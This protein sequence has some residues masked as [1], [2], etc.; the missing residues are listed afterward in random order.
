[1]KNRPFRLN[2]DRYS[3]AANVLELSLLARQADDR[4]HGAFGTIKPGL[5]PTAVM[6]D[7]AKVVSSFQRH[8]GADVLAEGPD[9]LIFVESWAN[10]TF[11]TIAAASH[12]RASEVLGTVTQGHATDESSAEVAVALWR[13]KPSGGGKRSSQSLP[14]QRWSEIERNYPNP[15]RRQLKALVSRRE[16]GPG[17][18]RLILFHG[19]PG[20][21][22]TT[23]VRALIHE[24]SSWCESQLVTDPDRLFADSE[25]LVNVL[26]SQEG[27]AAPTVLKRAGEAKWK[28]LVA[29]D[30][31]AYLR[32][33][34]R[35]EAGAALG[36]LLNTTDGL[37][38]LSTNALV[39][40]STNE[41]L[42]RLHP[43]LIRPGRC[44][45]HVEFVRFSR[46]EAKVWLGCEGRPAADD[47]SLAELFQARRGG[48][49]LY[50]PR[51]ST[52]T[53]L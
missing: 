25:Y 22:K 23:A 20:T 47:A 6:P 12:E 9:Y 32:S 13:S 18:G 31:D 29:E 7:E 24:W 17:E 42:L 3:N 14:A 48:G 30:A 26:Q 28:L 16:V 19:E 37:L 2:L 50:T 53:Y 39:L 51:L 21:G 52:G 15:V 33:T 40:L 35:L 46:Q 10:E 44:L 38:G 43:A 34:A 4:P 11:V 27:R 5:A 41:E 36:R 49:L 8:N 45:A 1:M